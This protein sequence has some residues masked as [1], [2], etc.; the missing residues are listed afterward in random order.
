MAKEIIKNNAI[1]ITGT[2][3]ATYDLTELST[4]DTRSSSDERLMVQVWHW[5]P[6]LSKENPH[7][8]PN[9]PSPE[10]GQIW[11]SQLVDSK[12]DPEIFE[13]ISKMN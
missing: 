11:L 9:P 12:S 4:K 5:S 13:S 8:K 3:G 2:A 7:S 10:I 1:N 6:L